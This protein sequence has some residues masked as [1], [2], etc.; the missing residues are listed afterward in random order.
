M[1]HRPSVLVIKSARP[2]AGMLWARSILGAAADSCKTRKITQSSSPPSATSLR[3]RLISLPAA[4]WSV[5][6]R[7]RPVVA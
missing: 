2:G 1:L 7:G 4:T 6:T 3:L 5:S